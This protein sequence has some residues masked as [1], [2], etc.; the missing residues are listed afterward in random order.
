MTW[1]SKLIR[2]VL[3]VGVVGAL[4]LAFAANYV[5]FGDLWSW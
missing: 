2:L 1:N 5:D 4:A 3:V